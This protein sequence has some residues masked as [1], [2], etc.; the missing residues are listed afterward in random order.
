M[1]QTSTQ[2]ARL[3]ELAAT[4]QANTDA[5]EAAPEPGDPGAQ[6]ST[7][8]HVP[9][10]ANCYAVADLVVAAR[11]ERQARRKAQQILD[12]TRF[13]VTANT[14]VGAKVF[15]SLMQENVDLQIL[16]VQDQNTDLPPVEEDA[17]RARVEAEM[18]RLLPLAMESLVIKEEG[19]AANRQNIRSGMC[20]EMA[21]DLFIHF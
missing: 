18:G 6:P 4:T 16:E 2:T 13:Q 7:H 14:R 17:V 11:D 1:K 10:N 15:T 8:F 5:H 12:R 3:K 9:A 20:D 19:P 21:H